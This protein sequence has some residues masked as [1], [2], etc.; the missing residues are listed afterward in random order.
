MSTS[1]TRINLR[2]D[3]K[4]EIGK[5]ATQEESRSEWALDK[6]E[7]SKRLLLSLLLLLLF[8]CFGFCLC[9]FDMKEMTSLFVTIRR[10]Y[11]NQMRQAR[12]AAMLRAGE[13][14]ENEFRGGSGRDVDNSSMQ[15]KETQNVW[16]QMQ[17]T[18]R[19]SLSSLL[20]REDRK[21]FL[22][23][24][25]GAKGVRWSMK[26]KEWNGEVH[27]ISTAIRKPHLKLVAMSV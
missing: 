2:W 4:R 1:F 8:L 11:S 16:T 5:F 13:T 17:V 9:L 23:V 20:P 3:E 19:H 21:W 24:Q 7:K 15:T 27:T 6:G 26:E 12:A 10:D 18:G 14:C 22:K 25:R